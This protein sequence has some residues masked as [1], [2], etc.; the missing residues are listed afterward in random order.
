MNIKTKLSLILTLIVIAILIFFSILVYYFSYSN[1]QVKFRE[2][3]LEK[4]ENTAILLINVS[5]VDSALLKKIH[6]STIPF[7]EEEIAILDSAGNVI[8]SNDVFYLSPWINGQNNVNREV[9]F[10]SV[11]R[12][13]GVNYQHH[14]KGMT[15]TVLVLAYDKYRTESLA[16]LRKILFWSIL[17]SIFL[18]VILSYLFSMK[19]MKP[20]SD[21]IRNVKEINTSRLSSRINEGNQKDEIAQ[22][23]ITFNG[24]LEKLEDAFRNQQEFVSNA[25]HELRTPLTVMIGETNYILSH[26]RTSEE[27]RQ[28]LSKQIDDLKKLNVLLNT[29]LA[30]AQVNRD[31]GTV[32]SDIRI[33][34]IVYGA[35]HQ[36]KERYPGRKILMK[37]IYPENESDLIVRGDSG[38]LEIAFQNVIDNACKFSSDDVTV[39]FSIGKEAIRIIVTDNGIGIPEGEIDGICRPFQ[40]ASNSRYKG[41]FGIGLSL[42]AR[43][44][45]LHDAALMINSI[46]NRGTSVEISFTKHNGI[47]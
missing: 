12:K 4:A 9:D 45:E 30:L 46:E 25:S 6:Q 33:D 26:E 36:V 1:Q 2:S 43:I 35:I 37:I 22:L 23:A 15:Y 3:L 42:V 32:F 29:L 19:A 44:L 39:E 16:E 40:R 8:Y 7:N 41:G 21:M 31:T 20:I 14:F 13:D 28:H 47:K 38:M 11:A 17:F 24:L 10:F 18:T 27:Y 34:E 5:E